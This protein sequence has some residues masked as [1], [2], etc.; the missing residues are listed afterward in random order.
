MI[1]LTW[2]VKKREKIPV[3]RETLLHDG[4]VGV[5]RSLQKK[6]KNGS[7]CGV[8]SARLKKKKE[9]LQRGGEDHFHLHRKDVGRRNTGKKKKGGDD[10]QSRHPAVRVWERPDILQGMKANIKTG[11]NKVQAL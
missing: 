2:Y 1:S 3:G 10:S 5:N 4:E 11:K 8:H 7:V 9:R 6:E